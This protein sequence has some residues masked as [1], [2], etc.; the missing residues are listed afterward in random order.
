MDKNRVLVVGATGYVGI[1]L[2][3]QL[4]K[5][6]WRVRAAARSTEKMKRLPWAGD[7]GVESVRADVFDRETLRKACEG[8]SAAYYLVH[9]MGSPRSDFSRCDREGAANMVWAAEKAQLH[10]AI[11]P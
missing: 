6:G 8:C 10:P 3:A 7:P 11:Y 4:R 9:S 2:V 1:R 5:E